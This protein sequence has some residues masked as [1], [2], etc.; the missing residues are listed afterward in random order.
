MRMPFSSATTLVIAPSMSERNRNNMMVVE[1]PQGSVRNALNL[2]SHPD[3]L[4]RPVL[5]TGTI[6][7]S[8]YGYPGVKNTKG[9]MLL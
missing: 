2:V 4:G 6:T 7:A 5:V 9:Y 1:L 8:Y 3:Y